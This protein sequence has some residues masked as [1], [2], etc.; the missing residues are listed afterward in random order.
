MGKEKTFYQ[1]LKAKG[2]TRRQFLKFCGIMGAMLGLQQSG[3]AQVVDALR[4]IDGVVVAA[5]IRKETEG[6]KV[7]LRS[8]SKR[9]S[10]GKIARRLNG[11][12]HEMAAG[13]SIDAPS[14]GE[15]EQILANNVEMELNEK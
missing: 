12:G 4:A 8:K 6:F 7:S 1:E 15:A 5:V 11:G 10:V 14:I 3:L 13:C 2:Y 9:V